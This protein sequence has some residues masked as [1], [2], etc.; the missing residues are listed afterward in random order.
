MVR[1]TILIGALLT[2]GWASAQMEKLPSSGKEPAKS[3]EPPRYEN[4]PAPGES[5]SRDTLIDISPPP[6]DAKNH[7]DSSSSVADAQADAS[8]VQEMR[9][10]D[11][12]R[13][14]KNM[15]VGDF[16]F[17]RQNYKAALDRY[18]EALEYKPND[19]VANYR[20]A[21]CLEKLDHPESAA[22]HYQEY[23]KI[24]PNGEYSAAA[25]KALAALKSVQKK[26][27]APQGPQAKN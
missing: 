23:L 20:M 24:L 18:H 21:E 8:D 14:A 7:P 22:D 11:P 2:A 16:Y 17:R 9:P 27:Q 13:A 15:E 6:D 4:G 26:D 5:S 3:Q 19:A 25:R 10:W 12:H 1:A